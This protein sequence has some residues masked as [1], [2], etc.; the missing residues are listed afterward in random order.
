MARVTETEE[1]VVVKER[2]VIRDDAPRS[3]PVGTILLI[4]LILFVLFVL[5]SW[6]P[7]GGSGDGGTTNVNA[8]TPTT[9]S[10]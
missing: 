7:W 1:P 6:Q 9:T 3:N 8:P 5:F 10:E 4:L 2:E